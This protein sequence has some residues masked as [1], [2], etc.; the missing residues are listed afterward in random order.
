VPTSPGRAPPTY[1]LTRALV[2]RGLGAI[3]FVA[4]FSLA[5]Q[6]QPLIGAGGLLP[7]SAYLREVRAEAGGTLSAFA[8]L[9]GLFWL[10]V[11]DRFLVAAAWAGVAGSLLVAAGF[12]NVLLLAALWFLYMSF[13]HVG[14]VFYGYGWEFLLLETGFLAIFLC[15][16]LRRDAFPTHTPPPFIVIVLLRWLAFRVMFGAGLIKMRGDPCWRDLTC[17]LYHY[18]TQP[19]PNPLSWLLHQTPPWVH[20]AEVLWNHFVEL[21]VPFGLFGPRRLRTIAGLLTIAFQATLVVSGNLSWLNYLTIVICVACLDD[22]TLAVLIPAR[23]RLR[24]AEAAALAAQAPAPRRQRHVT[25]ALAIVVGVLSLQPAL[26]L[27]SPHQ[28]MNQSFDPFH[29]VN[30]Y[31]AFGSVGRTRQEVILSG[32]YDDPTRPDARWLEYD[33]PCKPGNLHRRP[34]FVAPFQLR[35]DWQIWFAAMSH[36][37]REPWLVHL[38]AQLLDGNRSA[39]SLLAPGPLHARAPR[40][41]RAELYEYHFTR[42]GDGSPGWWRRERVGEYLRV[43]TR[44][45]PALRGFVEDHGWR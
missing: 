20:R 13:V 29:L 42:I 37:E 2:L 43:L 5:L 17:L 21:V 27:L 35:L 18:E 34:C 30:T 11:S 7:A 6:V 24:A 45:D 39:L 31:G 40:A 38:V 26:N 12:A 25:I 36:P 33:F 41:I 32:T 28:A 15:P 9:P 14:Q 22:Q 8:A 19:L 3:Y 10:G 16:L 44:E 1:W 23:F 4:F